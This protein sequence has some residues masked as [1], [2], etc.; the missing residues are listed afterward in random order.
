[1]AKSANQKLKLLYL[2]KYLLEHS[3]ENHPVT[4]ADMIAY[5]ATQDI[6]AERKSIYDD[7]EALRQF[8]LDIIKTGGRSTGYFVGERSFELPELKLLV[9]SVQSSKFI[10]HRKTLSLIK[11]IES[12]ASVHDAQQLQRQVFVRN[13]VKSMN[14]SVYYNVDEISGAITQDRSI[15]FRYFEYTTSKEHRYRRDGN[16]Y[17]ISP[18]ALMWDDENYYLLGWEEDSHQMKHFRVDKMTNISATDAPRT[19]KERFEG[20]DMS[21]Y[22]QKVFGMFSGEPKQVKL[23]FADHLVGAVIDRFGKDLIIMPEANGTFTVNLDVVV[24][25]LFFGW[26]FGF[27]TEVEVLHPAEI[28]VEMRSL[29][30]A[31]A[32]K[33]GG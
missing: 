9:D 26:V 20:I 6:S 11:K 28:R 18:F 16:Y 21:A 13:R 2:Q 14:E 30:L 24:S 7:L 3:D 5:L 22:T 19:G 23:R 32:E 12:L 1:M 10:T 8:G 27:G 31:V 17:E 29:A 25:P 33:N 4:V 15:H